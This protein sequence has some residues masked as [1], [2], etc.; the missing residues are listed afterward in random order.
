MSSES[1][2]CARV[3]VVCGVVVEREKVKCVI[4]GAVKATLGVVRYES[5]Q[6]A[7]ARVQSV[8]QSSLSAGVVA[9]PVTLDPPPGPL[10]DPARAS[11]SLRA[12]PCC[13]AP[14]STS[15]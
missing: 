8:F 15:A 4:E 10:D 2:V 6:L 9:L 13:A 14:P 5:V 11:P 12:L 3:R 7:V 1:T